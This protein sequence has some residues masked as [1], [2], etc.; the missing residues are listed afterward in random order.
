[1][2]ADCTYDQTLQQPSPNQIESPSPLIDFAIIL[3][4]P[5]ST[6]NG[7]G[8][9][10]ANSCET[11]CLDSKCY[12]TPNEFE[13]GPHSTFPIEILLC[14]KLDTHHCAG[15]NRN[16]ISRV[17]PERLLLLRAKEID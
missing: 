9:V 5:S 1:M 3:G 11:S 12:R 14:A 17:V 10:V 8:E 6:A 16:A 4:T 15:H 7:N 13:R 2:S